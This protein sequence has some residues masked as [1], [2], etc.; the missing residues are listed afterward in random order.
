[1]GKVSMIPLSCTNQYCLIKDGKMIKDKFIRILKAPTESSDG[2]LT[3]SYGPDSEMTLTF[4]INSTNTFVFEHEP[5]TMTAN[6]YRG[7]L[8]LELAMSAGYLHFLLCEDEEE[9]YCDP[10]WEMGET[11]YRLSTCTC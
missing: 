6:I 3:I 1:M 9:Y 10:V 7:M 8:Y 5:Y 4:S 2:K 11:N